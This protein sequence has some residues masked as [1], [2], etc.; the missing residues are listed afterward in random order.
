MP[1]SERYLA[2]ARPSSGW[3]MPATLISP[4][5]IVSSLLIHLHSVDLPDPEGPTITTTSPGITCK[6]MLCITCF[7]PKT[8]LTPSTEISGVSVRST[9]SIPRPDDLDEL[10]LEITGQVADGSANAVAGNRVRPFA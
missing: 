3:S 9:I 8:L 1:T 5:L 2:K 10:Q 4:L 7:S 6:L